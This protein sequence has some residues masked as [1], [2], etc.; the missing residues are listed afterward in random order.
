VHGQRTVVGVQLAHKL[1]LTIIL[2]SK[3]LQGRDNHL[4]KYLELG[5]ALWA[6][7]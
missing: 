7:Q 3:M 4:V 6:S 1:L 2:D 5:L